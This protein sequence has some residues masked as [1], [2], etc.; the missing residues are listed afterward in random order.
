MPAQTSD[1]RIRAQK[2]LIAPA[3]LADELP[4]S[5]ASA[6]LVAQARREVAAIVTGADDRLLVVVGPCSIHDPAAALEYAARLKS[7]VPL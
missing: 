6:G 4:L 5:E 7:A 1:L 2:P 3:V